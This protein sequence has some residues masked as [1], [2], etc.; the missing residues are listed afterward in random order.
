MD[1][2][3]KKGEDMDS[4]FEGMVLFNPAEEKDNGSDDSL[5]ISSCSQSQP[6]DENL[7]SDLT[8][9]VDPLQNLEVAEAERDLQSR[10]GHAPARRRKRSGL[11]IGYGRDAFSS[12]D[13]PHTPSPL[14][15]PISD[16][17]SVGDADAVRVRDTDTDTDTETLPSI[18]TATA[19][20]TDDPVT[21]T[22]TQP[23]NESENQNRK[24]QQSSTESSSAE[25]RQ[26]KSSIHD[27][28]NH[29]T[30][31]V[32]S[33]SSA[34]KD[35][36]RNRRKTVENANLASLKH[37]ELEK[38]L[39]EACEAEDF[40][41]AE[42]VSDDLSAAEKEKQAFANSLREADAFV[43][44]LDLKLQHALDSQ[45]AIEEQCAILLDHYATNALNN[46]DF[47]MKKASSVYSKEMDQWLSSSEAL[48]VKKMEL[49]IESQFMNEARLELNNTIE[50]SIQNDKREKEILCKRKDVLMGEL[51]Q[52]LALVKQKEMEIADND[53][54]LEAVENKINKVVSGFKEMQSSIDVKYDKLQSVLAQ[55]KLETETLVLKKEEIDNFLIREEEMGARLREFVR[56]STE[57]A[58]GYRKIVKLRRSLMSSILKSR[59]D[60][61]TLSKKEEKLS[62]DVK[63]F[64]QE[65]S[66]ARASLQELSSRKSSIQQD[67]ASFKQRIV[68]IDKR[69]PELEAE[70]KV[71]TTARNFKEAARIATEAKSLC[72]EKESIQINM[73]MATL[74]L[75]KL[76]EEIND[77]LNKLQ[78]TEGMILLKEKELAMVRYQ[79]LLLAAATARAEKAAAVEMGDVEEANLLLAEAEAADCDAEKLKSTYKFE[80]EDFTD[81]QRHLIS[82]DLV[83]HLD[84]KQLEELAVSLRLFT[85]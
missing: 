55:V 33:A 64:Q 49:E 37:M 36:I 6:L 17:D 29:A 31:L 66:A 40:E 73:D 23:S 9:V 12:N 71:A 80:A 30:Q 24:H 2:E 72:V 75:E 13:P 51:E 26:L 58:E 53:S 48:E 41:R 15:Q 25:F 22:L 68:F 83:S 18:T 34:R 19:T 79:K 60:K 5:T 52:L 62:G 67:I 81:L 38:Q 69:V 82:M 20:A 45:L 84:Q 8:L 54:N 43:D 85:G 70:K 44:A 77:T 42:K 59:E 46:A 27:K 1:L 28:L 39:E 14:P 3:G 35:S 21:V 63:L 16:S 50:H 57:E 10:Q 11:R 74:N 4:L 32:K 78:E 61:L 7:F 76:E 65:V 47:S 56:I